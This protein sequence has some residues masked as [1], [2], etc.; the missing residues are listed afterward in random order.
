MGLFKKNAAQPSLSRREMLERQYASARSNFLLI[1]VFTA[2]NILLLLT[3][4]GFYF[5]FSAAMPYYSVVLGMVFTGK[6]PDE[7]YMDEN[8]VVN[9]PNLPS[10]F[11]YVAIAFAAVC[12]L[13]YLLF[14]LASK[15]HPA[16]L[17]AGTVFFVLDTVSLLFF[18]LL[19]SGIGQFALDFVFHALVLWM[20]I[21]GV[22]GGL[23][24]KKLPPEEPLVVPVAAN[25]APVD[26][27]G[28]SG[29]ID[30]VSTESDGTSGAIDGVP[31]ESDGTSGTV[32]AVPT[33]SDGTSETIDGVPTE[34]DGV[35]GTIDEASTKSDSTPR[36]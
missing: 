26:S 24:L 27:N 3:N 32:D 8:G 5:L 25:G 15:K 19:F 20:L 17:L 34:S 21:S 6:F 14:Y 7:A 36:Q 2:V 11:L 31:T 33:E 29:A 4:T 13:V 23:K 16:F 10:A 9:K 28:T 18:V 30:G 22:I 12:L 1:L 35:S